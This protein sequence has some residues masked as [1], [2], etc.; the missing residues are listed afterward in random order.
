[1]RLAL[2]Y[3]P[4]HHKA[5]N[6]NLRTVDEEFGV[7]PH[8]GFGWVAG[9][10]RAAGW[11]V[12]LFDAAVDGA[13]YDE[14][15][16][17]VRAWN[18]DLLGF[19]AHA[20][21]TF[22]DM[23]GWAARFKEDTGLPILAGGY[24]AA[25]YP[26]EILSHRCF[27][28][29]CQGGVRPFLGEFLRAFERQAGYERVAG[30]GY[31]DL[32][33]IRLNPRA[34]EVPFDRMP[35]PDRGIFDNSRYWSHVSQ[36]RNFTVGMSSVGCPYGCDFCCM[37]T[38]GFTAKPA[39]A[40]FAEMEECV[41]RHGIREIDWF[42]PVMLHDKRRI[43]ELAGLLIGSGLDIIWST[44]TRVEP[45]LESRR[46][47]KVD[48]AF[49]A[50]LAE[51]GCRRLFIGVES[52]NADI[53]RGLHKGLDV[54]PVR[55][56]FACLRDHGIMVLGFFMIG[57]P[58]ET[59]ATARQTIDYARSL[60]LDY[61][62]FSMTTMKPHT[63][64]AAEH[65]E[66]ALGMDYWREYVL[67]TVAERVLPAPWTDLT[68]EEIEELTKLGYLRFYFRPGYIASMLRKVRSP[69]ELAKYVRVALQMALRP[70]AF[71][72]SGPPP[73]NR[74]RRVL[75]AA[76]EGGLSLARRALGARPGGLSTTR[77]CV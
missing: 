4:F 68:R 75:R 16:R 42:D 65:L 45:M 5:F 52:A 70:A 37:R 20:V 34:G 47:G 54:R 48:V 11:E 41:R 9:E 23:L 58:G 27:D 28:F 3:P 46:G 17:R 1:M 53:Q 50:R 62:Q 57:S 30:L 38:S 21:Q 71:G 73:R 39:T 15:L 64:L 72:L 74:A 36:R 32:G 63:R 13:S 33:E 19:A 51:A 24:E 26:R 66:P 40:V 25:H 61:A 60:P 8:I 77:R 31:R 29:L 10:A 18:P 43:D 35:P 44:R 6:E 12:R 67:G 7:F 22:R 2:I 56:V 59:R 14:T 76:F 55:D 49:V 69:E